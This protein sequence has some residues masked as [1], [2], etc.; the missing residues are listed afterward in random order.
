[1]EKGRPP[2]GL[3]IWRPFQGFRSRVV[4]ATVVAAVTIVGIE[5]RL[6]GVITATIIVGIIAQ[7]GAAALAG[8]SDVIDP[9]IMRE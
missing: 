5:I 4:A 1:M 3:R 6:V 2:G 8:A 9:G 7:T